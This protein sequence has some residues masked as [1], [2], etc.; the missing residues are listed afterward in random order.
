MRREPPYGR[1]VVA[2]Q[3]FENGQARRV[4]VEDGWSWPPRRSVDHRA[5]LAQGC[6]QGFRLSASNSRNR[7]DREDRGDETGAVEDAWMIE[8]LGDE[9]DEASKNRAELKRHAIEEGSRAVSSIGWN[10]VD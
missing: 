2:Q 7:G 10:R 9:C 5:S 6:D 8:S 3:A 1:I 4:R